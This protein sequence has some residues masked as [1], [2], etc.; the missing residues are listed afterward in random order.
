M[1]SPKVC[2]HKD[3]KVP[4]AHLVQRK[5]KFKCCTSKGKKRKKKTQ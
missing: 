4:T 1:S 3:L 2:I 5:K